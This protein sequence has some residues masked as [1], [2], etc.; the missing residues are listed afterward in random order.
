M[1]KTN[2]GGKPGLMARRKSALKL[3]EAQ[4]EKFQKAGEDKAPWTSTRNGGKRVV[5]H[6]GRPFQKEVERIAGEIKHLKELIH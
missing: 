1:S 6:K 5:Y 4:L 3:L 2:G